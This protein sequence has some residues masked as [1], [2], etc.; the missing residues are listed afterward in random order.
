MVKKLN[1]YQKEIFSRDKSREKYEKIK[2]EI[3]KIWDSST[4]EE[5]N[6]F[7]RSGA[8]DMLYQ[9]LEYMD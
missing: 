5:K 7:E 3:E 8:L 1:E 9:S 6:E 4:Q 2:A